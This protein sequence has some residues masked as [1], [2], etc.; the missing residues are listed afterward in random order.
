[1]LNS[2]I[3]STRFSHSFP[4]PPLSQSSPLNNFT[5]NL[6]EAKAQKLTLQTRPQILSQLFARRQYTLFAMWRKSLL[7]FQL[8]DSLEKTNIS[9]SQWPS[10]F[11]STVCLS[12]LLQPGVSPFCLYYVYTHITHQVLLSPYFCANGKCQVTSI[13]SWCY[14]AIKKLQLPPRAYSTNL[15]SLIR[16]IILATAKF[17]GFPTPGMW[18]SRGISQHPFMHA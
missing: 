11:L 3:F 14:S 12:R 15:Y 6:R 17:S 18:S 4:C 1:M 5:S 13:P 2:K 7:K 10:L 8:R 16:A 9:H